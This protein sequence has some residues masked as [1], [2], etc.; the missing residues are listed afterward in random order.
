V[1]TFGAGL[2]GILTGGSRRSG[3]IGAV[4]ATVTV[5]SRLGCA[6]RSVAAARLACSA[7]VSGR[8]PGGVV[9]AG[10]GAGERVERGT[11]RRPAR[12]RLASSPADSGR[13]RTGVVATTRGG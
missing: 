1:A 12:V 8:T 11:L 5:G 6:G 7:G 13:S 4:A 3:W 9:Y 10:A 2:A